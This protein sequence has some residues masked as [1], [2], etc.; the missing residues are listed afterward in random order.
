MKVADISPRIRR[1]GR[2]A[3]LRLLSRLPYD[4]T[5]TIV[6]S[7]TARSGTTWVS[8]TLSSIPH[9]SILFEPFHLEHVPAANR[10]GLSWRTYLREGESCSTE[11]RFVEAVLTG[12][13]LNTWTTRE[14]D[15]V[16]RT[17][18]WIVKF[19]RANRMVTWMTSEFP[20]SR[21]MLL[22]RHPCAVVASQI[23]SEFPAAR[24]NDPKLLRDFPHFRPII[25]SLETDEEFFAADWA[26]NLAVPFAARRPWPWRI[27]AFERLVVQGSS[28][29]SEV[30]EQWHIDNPA[31]LASRLRQW[32]STARSREAQ[33]GVELLTEWKTSLRPDQVRRILDVAQSFQIRLYG[34]DPLPDESLLK[35]LE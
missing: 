18:T 7:G 21:V 32:S 26:L 25:E 35:Q 8:R 15:R 2:L 27:V 6:V 28:A 29:L 1:A 10:A 24:P 9:S 17:R 23:A 4:I 20:I 12:R 19:I 11:R 13:V 34:D 3:G 14:V 22:V 16:R 33:P 31:G 5:N 30:L